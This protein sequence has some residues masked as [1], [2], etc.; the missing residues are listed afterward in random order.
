MRL[1]EQIVAANHRAAEGDTGAGLRWAEFEQELPLIALTC[2]D[3]RLNNLFPA[4]LGIPQEKFIWLRNAGNIITGPQSSTMRSIA[5]ACAIKQGKEIV[6][7]G[8]T[9]CQVGKTSMLQLLESLKRMGVDR[10][11]LP[12]N[13]VEFFGMFA[14][15]RQNVVKSAELV[16]LSPLIGKQ[17]PVHGMMVDTETGRLEWVLNGYE[18]SANLNNVVEKF[19]MAASATMDAARAFG[20]VGI[21]QARVVQSEIGSLSQK[22]KQEFASGFAAEEIPTPPR[23]PGKGI[24]REPR[25]VR[26]RP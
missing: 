9:D 25:R 23:I 5:L 26:T 24:P 18:P 16:R 17:T 13:L 22:I 15:E 11:A 7:I 1:V 20:E 6:I 4:V 14:S 3:P 2:I 12:E 8:H 19:Q 21:E 10:H